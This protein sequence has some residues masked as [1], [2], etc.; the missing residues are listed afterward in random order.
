MSS[1]AVR[2]A[3]RARL[4]ANF[5]S[6]TI[7]ET[8]NVDE[9]PAVYEPWV[10]LEFLAGTE[11][12]AALG[13]SFYREAGTVQA[14]VF[15]PSGTGDA[16]AVTLADEIRAVFRGARFDGVRVD[17]VDPPTTGPGSDDG[18]W[19]RATIAFDY[20]FDHQPT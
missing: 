13:G 7:M 14:H 20:E 16:D 3:V 18:A 4:A 15:V 1:S 10:T 19:F 12:V 6:A 2:T 5:T 8:V 17:G 9:P 11:D